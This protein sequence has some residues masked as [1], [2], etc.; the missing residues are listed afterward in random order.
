MALTPVLP[1]LPE[2]AR[3]IRRAGV[4]RLHLILPHHRGGIRGNPELVPSGEEMLRAVRALYEVAAEIDLFV[5]NVPAWKRRCKAP[6]DFCAA[7]CK[8]LAV[9]PYGRLYAC[10]I[11]CGDPAFVAGDLRRSDLES[12]WRTSPA[13]RLLRHAHA[14]DRLECF[15]CP[16]VDACGGECWMQA[17]YRARMLEQPAGPAAPFPYCDLVRPMFDELM[18][19]ANDAGELSALA[20]VPACGEGAEGGCEGQAMAGEADYA[21]FDCI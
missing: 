12:V 20:G 10:P 2:M 7:G 17:H 11:T 13:F 9:D 8:D 6:Q 1:T 18:A 3:I 16:V 19:A 4:T 21:L 14:R 5:D 15:V